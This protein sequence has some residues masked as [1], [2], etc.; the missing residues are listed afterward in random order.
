MRARWV[1]EEEGWHRL[2]PRAWPEVRPKADEIPGI[3]EQIELQRC[4]SPGSARLSP[5]CA[6]L[7]F[8]LASA[9]VFAGVDPPAGVALYR[10]LASVRDLDGMVAAAVVLLEGLG[11]ERDEEEG[12]RLLRDASHRGSA[13]GLYELGTLLYVGGGG[14]EEDEAAAF[15][16]FQQAASQQHTSGMFM[17][18]DCLLEG[19]GCEQDLASA[20]PLLHASAV[21]GHRGARQHLR[22]L[23]DGQ[24]MGF[25]GANGPARIAV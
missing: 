16:L 11:V 17:V 24:W 8:D 25:G 10:G 15:A 5:T 6:K 9:L 22:Q 2:P 7:T 1:K 4:P 20:V 18:A 14:L 23:L 12:V 3:R 21:N 13:Q 19:T